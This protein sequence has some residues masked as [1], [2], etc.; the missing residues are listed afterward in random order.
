M[1]S[2]PS[3]ARTGS[4]FRPIA[5]ARAARHLPL[6]VLVALIIVLLALVVPRD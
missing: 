2:I 5:T 6:R 1:P 4:G 3:I